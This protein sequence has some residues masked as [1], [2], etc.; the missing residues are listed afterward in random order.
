M[1]FRI[2]FALAIMAGLT[3]ALALTFQHPPIVSSQNGYRGL[4]MDELDTARNARLLRASVEIPPAQDP[5]PP[6]GPLATTEYKNVQVLTDLSVDQF[7]R[8]ML[9]ITEWVAPD[10]GC[11]YCHAEGEDLS[12]DKLYTKVV[13]RRMLQMTRTINSAW[14]P[15]VADTGVTCFT[16]HRGQPIPAKVWTTDPGRPHAANAGNPAGQN[17]PTDSNGHTS[18]PI[19][20]MTA[21]LTAPGSTRVVS[22]SAYPG[23]NPHTIKQTEM[24]YALMVNMSEGL[25][26]NC[27]YCHNT[28]S[29]TSWDQSPPQRAVAYHGIQMVR[30]INANFL[31]PLQ[32][33]WPADRLGPLGD[34]PKVSCVTCHQGLPK[35]LFGISMLK[36][37]PELAGPASPPK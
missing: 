18:L 16:C 30:D 20:P 21:Y 13:A 3:V 34:G 9:S 8:V 25:G 7:N 15:H 33:Q 4:G 11:G 37:N 6:G 14:K 31:M 24:T 17:Q 28:R 27:T 5:A 1:N 23:T 2:G 22:A 35:P 10:Q 12:S 36:D 32:S 29:F 19:D 26:V